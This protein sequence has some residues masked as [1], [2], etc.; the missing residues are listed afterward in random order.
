MGNHKFGTLYANIIQ[1]KSLETDSSGKIKK[2]KIAGWAS[3]DNLDSVGDIVPATTI[4]D[5]IQDYAEWGNIREMHNPSLGAKGVADIL[6]IENQGLWIEATIVDEDCVEKI[7]VGIYKGFSI[8]YITLEEHITVMGNILDKILLVEIS[9]VDRPANKE[10]KFTALEEH[11]K[12]LSIEEIKSKQGDKMSVKTLTLEQKANM[13]DESFA[14]VGTLN[15][16]YCRIMAYKSAVGEVDSELAISA[17]NILN[18]NREDDVKHLTGEEKKEC[19]KAITVSL[20]DAEFD[21]E[22]P[23][24]ELSDEGKAIVPEKAKSAEPKV[25]EKQTALV[26]FNAVLE[27]S[28]KK[29]GEISKHI[30]DMKT[31]QA[32]GFSAFLKKFT[33][34][35]QK[36]TKP[37]EGSEGKSIE[38]ASS[39]TEFNDV[40]DLE[41]LRWML[42]DVT[43]ILGDTLGN[44]L[45]SEDL[46]P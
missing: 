4:D 46:S 20:K 39:P 6:I 2:L 23:V 37:V 43:W 29:F 30:K 10:A 28:D 35:F 36:E 24:L 22:I 31:E 17:I 11:Y 9:V 8:G 41:N 26:D 44:I 16:K 18:S 27:A 14:F 42:Y 32:K 5:A 34:I 12:S 3:K 40:A 13:P 21:G 25:E 7:L 38:I 45:W 19:Y 33:E 15:E 1:T